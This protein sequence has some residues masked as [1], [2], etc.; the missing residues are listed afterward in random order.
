M[1]WDFIVEFPVAAVGQALPL[2]QR[3]INAARVQLEVG[4]RPRGK[5]HPRHPVRS[6]AWPRS[7]APR[8]SSCS[9]CELMANFSPL[10]LST[11]GNVLARVL[12]RLQVAEARKVYDINHTDISYDYESVG[13]SF[14]P[15][16]IG[17]WAAPSPACGENPSVQAIEKRRQLVE[18]GYENGQF[19][20][21]RRSSR[22]RARSISAICCLAS[23]PLSRTDFE[24][25]TA[26]SAYDFPIKARY[27][28][29]SGICVL[30]H[31]RWVHARFHA[32]CVTAC[33]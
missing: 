8:S 29:T 11:L 26:G 5:S 28:T 9:A 14:Q 22:S 16:P 3:S 17:L 1:G 6:T 24:C 12:R 18:L 13:V 25:S 19:F 21:P 7:L 30:R 4:T 33:R 2:D 31:L 20:R 10:I 15:T 23:R 27:S 32:R